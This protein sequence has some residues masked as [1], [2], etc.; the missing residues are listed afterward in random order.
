MCNWYR[1][2]RAK[3]RLESEKPLAWALEQAEDEGAVVTRECVIVRP[4]PN[5]S[6]SPDARRAGWQTSRNAAD[7]GGKRRRRRLLV[8]VEIEYGLL[9]S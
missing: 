6:V 5:F 7:V 1:T 8:L 9:L 2:L 4:F 3:K